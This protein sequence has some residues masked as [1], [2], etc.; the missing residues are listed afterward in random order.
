MAGFKH[1]FDTMNPKLLLA[2]PFFSVL[3]AGCQKSSSVQP[4][5][6]Y[7]GY[8]AEHIT[9]F[10]EAGASS[11]F[12]AEGDVET[13][14]ISDSS[15]QVTLPAASRGG[16]LWL[17][18]KH[19]GDVQ[20]EY[21]ITFP[22][23]SG[24]HV[25]YFFAQRLDES[26]VESD[27]SIQKHSYQYNARTLSG[28]QVAVHT[29]DTDFQHHSHCRMRKNPGQLLL[30]NANQ[31]PCQ[32]SQPYLIDFIRTGNRMQ[33][34]VDEER[35]HDVRDKAVFRPVIEEGHIGLWFEGINIA[36]SVVLRKVNLFKLSPE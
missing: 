20:L 8:N 13:V 21:E 7:Y 18:G 29:Y 5:M 6:K 26:Q 30:S 1:P 15:M 32:F 36:Y 2:V 10:H 24:L 35:I 25:L 9:G 12:I 17:K 19:E 33:F 3:I 4:F 11:G 16:I 27:T 22:D 31:D 34:F 28:Y 14:M 23:S